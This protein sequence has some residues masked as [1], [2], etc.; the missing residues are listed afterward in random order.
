M[1]ELIAR[2]MARVRLTEPF[3]Y[4]VVGS[5]AYFAKHGKPRK[6]ED[7]L[8]HECISF[9]WPTSDALY[10]WELERGRRKWRVP[11][12]GGLVTNNLEFC[13]AM[14][15]AGLGLAYLADLSMREQLADGRLVAALEDYAP[16]EQGIFLCSP[17]R[18]QQ[19]PRCGS[20]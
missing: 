15:E 1:T 20:S 18:E 8:Q 2:D 7:L 17:S 12:R 10:A 19:S 3:K 6:P 13:V 5:P 4:F 14:A 11:V 16:T 9:R